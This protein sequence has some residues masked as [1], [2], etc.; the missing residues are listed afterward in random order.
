M[1]LAI[2]LARM[3]TG[4]TSPNPAVG[5]VVVSHGDI[6]GVGAHFKAGEAHAEVHALRMA[7][8]RAEG[9]VI[10]V[11]LEPCAHFGQTPPCADLIIRKKLKRVVIA[12]LDPNPL[13][14]GK[15]IERMRRAGIVV[16]TGV[17][18]KE[19]DAINSFFFHYIRSGLPFVTLKIASSLDGKTATSAGESKWITNDLSRRNG[20]VLRGHYD[21]ILVGIGTVMADDPRLT[22]R[23]QAEDRQPIRVVL[24]THLRIREDAT[25]LTDGIAP[26]WIMTGSVIDQKKAERIRRRQVEI[27]QLPDE[28]IDVMKVLSCLGERGVMSLLVEGGATVHGS[29][30]KAGAFDRLIAYVAPKLIGGDAALPAIGGSGIDYLADAAQLSIESVENLNG[31]LKIIASRRR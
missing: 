24:D 19:A 22:A 11:T 13:V 5:A 17:M 9:G 30:L 7:G 1:E 15:G 25:L 4:Q 16:D 23:L 14:S 21:A 8:D 3:T 31:D 12:S 2:H 26:T 10:Y 18:R 29:F 6:V 27:V 20:H 28:R